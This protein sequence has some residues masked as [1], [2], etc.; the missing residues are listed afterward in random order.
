[1]GE[2]GILTF[3]TGIMMEI[4][5][6]IEK[7]NLEQTIK[8]IRGDADSAFGKIVRFEDTQNK[9]FNID[10]GL[11]VYRP[12]VFTTYLKQNGIELYLAPSKCTNKN[13]VVDRVIRTIRDKIGKNPG[14]FY[15]PSI[16]AKAV[17]EYNNSPHSAFNHE[18]TPKEVQIHKDLEEYYIRENLRRIDEVKHLQKIEGHF[19]YKPGDIL[20]VH[21]DNA[22]NAD[23]LNKKRR[24]FNRLATF[25]AY[26]HGNVVCQVLYKN[27][28]LHP[29]KLYKRPI[30]PPNYYTKYLANSFKEIPKLYL[31]LYF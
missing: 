26:D 11:E 8:H 7:M 9:K 28:Q 30:T 2:K 24:I 4:K 1:M 12:N 21:I 15:K 22:K 17:E 29:N 5:N 14:F 10:L 31:S 18:F 23:K 19:F 20:L 16:I 25:L 27:D 6:E 13:R 3:T